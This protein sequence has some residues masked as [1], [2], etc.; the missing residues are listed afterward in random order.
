MSQYVETPTKAFPAAGAL[1]KFVRVK[2]DSAGTVSLAGVTDKDIGIV[3][4][5]AFSAGDMVSVRLRSASGTHKAI[6]NAAITRGANVFTAASGKV[7]PTIA[8]SF[9]RGTAMEAAAADGDIIEVL[10]MMGDTAQ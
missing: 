4:Q 1:A 8:T 5:Q 7:G 3:E 10:P 6:A 9:F 2:L